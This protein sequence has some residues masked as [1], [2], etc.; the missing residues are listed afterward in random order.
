MRRMNR[1]M[2]WLL[3]LSLGTV[4]VRAGQRDLQSTPSLRPTNAPRLSALL[5]DPHGEP[6]ASKRS[7]LKQRARL[8]E[9]WHGVLGGFPRH[10]APLTAEVLATEDMGGFTR[11]FVK[12]QVE[13]GLFPDGY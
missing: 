13:D 6:V 8:K 12:Y 2:A 9:R 11:Q 4:A 10:K 7:W 3:L 1:V 5:V